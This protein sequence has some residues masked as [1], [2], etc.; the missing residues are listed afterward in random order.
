MD[1]DISPDSNPESSDSG[2]EL[3]ESEVVEEV[4]APRTR[5]KGRVASTSKPPPKPGKKAPSRPKTTRTRIS[6]SALAGSSKSA[7]INPSEAEP[8]AS[9]VETHVIASEAEHLM[10]EANVDAPA[11]VED[12]PVQ[13]IHTHD[14]LIHHDQQSNVADLD[15][16]GDTP[17]P[18]PRPEIPDDDHVPMVV[19][20]TSQACGRGSSHPPSHL[21][22][23]LPPCQSVPL[24]ALPALHLEM[25]APED[26]CLTV[27]Q[28]IR[29]E[30]EI[31]YDQLRQ[32]GRK[33]I[34]LFEG[35]AKEVRQIIEAL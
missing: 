19:D 26:R 9:K 14:D 28:W 25:L 7:I 20:E 24:A 11:E 22:S 17:N 6:K 27:E 21:P 32:D 33:Q 23:P 12:T 29:R 18:P 35:R 2:D 16:I 4:Q 10:L 5:G 3:A 1:V 31:S 15:D 30:I 34:S 13:Q 8:I